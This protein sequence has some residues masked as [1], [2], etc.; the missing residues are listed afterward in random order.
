MLSKH[1]AFSPRTTNARAE[2]NSSTFTDYGSVRTSRRPKPIIADF[3]VSTS[4]GKMKHPAT[5]QTRSPLAVTRFPVTSAD[6]QLSAAHMRC[7]LDAGICCEA[8]RCMQMNAHV[9]GDLCSV[10][11]VARMGRAP[12]Q[13]KRVTRRWKFHGRVNSS[14]A[15]AIQ[16]ILPRPFPSNL[17]SS[18]YPQSLLRG[19]EK[20]ASRRAVCC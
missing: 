18:S 14:R 5:T 11:S 10:M 20:D 16:S 13:G 17:V 19:P 12:G 1:L 8:P 4:G 15:S 6:K 9:H 3:C 7:G 2:D